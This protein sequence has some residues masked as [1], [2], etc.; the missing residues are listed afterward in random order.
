MTSSKMIPST[1]ILIGDN[2]CVFFLMIGC[3][4]AAIQVSR[5]QD[6]FCITLM[7]GARVK[8]SVVTDKSLKLE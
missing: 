3:L 6:G 5:K 4:R 8:M 7:S 2:R 1:I